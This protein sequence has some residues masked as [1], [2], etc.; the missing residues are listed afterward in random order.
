LNASEI[1]NSH[2][3]ATE[4]VGFR[5]Q[6]GEW[7]EFGRQVEHDFTKVISAILAF[8]TDL[9]QEG[10]S[11]IERYDEIRGSEFPAIRSICVVGSGHWEISKDGE[12]R[13]FPQTY[14]LAEVVSFIAIVMNTYR[15]VAATRKEQRLGLYLIEK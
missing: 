4:L 12:W 9:S 15:R 14:P 3:S 11:E 10:K 6:S 5:Y 7:D 1:L 2:K 13:M 8:S